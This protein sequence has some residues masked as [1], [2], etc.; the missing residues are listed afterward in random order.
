VI[1]QKEERRKEERYEISKQKQIQGRVER[2]IEKTK[3]SRMS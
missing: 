3:V 2:L 1:R